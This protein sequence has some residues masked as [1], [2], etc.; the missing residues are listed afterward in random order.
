MFQY[1]QK[2]RNSKFRDAIWPIR[3][4]ELRKFIPMAIL[5][6][7]VNL[8]LNFLRTMKD[9][10]VTT[11]MGAEVISFIK[12]WFEIPSGV[13]FVL[14]YAGMCNIMSTERAFRIILMVFLIFFAAFAFILFPYKEY[15]HPD[16]ESVASYM[17]ILPN[18]KWFITIWGKWS[19]VLFYV[20][21]ELWPVVVLGLLWQLANKITS[22]EEAK[23]FY[24]FFTFFGQLNLLVC[25]SAIGYFAS[26]N[27]IFK[28]LFQNAGSTTE[29][30]VKSI[31]LVVLFSGVITLFTHLY[32]EKKT[33]KLDSSARKIVKRQKLKL[34]MIDS[35]KMIL[36][37]KYLG[38]IC[39]LMI[40][41]SVAAILLEGIWFAKVRQLYPVAEQFMAY[42]GKFMFFTGIS[43]LIFALLGSSII[44]KLGWIFGSII[45]P[46]VTLI[47]GS[48]FFVFVIIQ[49]SLESIF[50]DS[51]GLAALPIIVF[52]GGIQN[53][54]MK[55]AKYTLFDATK[56]MSYIPLDPE[57]KTKGQAAVDVVGPKI[58]KAIGAI[59]PFLSFTIF[60]SS[61]YQDIAGF[62]L[63][64][65]ASTCIIWISAVVLLSREYY[66]LLESKE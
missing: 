55:G 44:R 31:M 11:F 15:F 40:S 62:L 56:E 1:F 13:L 43:A 5:M 54:F 26:G 22:T 49:D 50:S 35:M 25:G 34:G 3:S 29:V 41:Y 39:I 59:V 38:L 2:V 4:G 57:I 66:A 6:F 17:V 52:C 24:S 21:A 7:A 42:Q 20:M 36:S 18:L 33:M 53:V 46:V 8:N 37:S 60:P 47:A 28:S 51:L 12:I 61:G 23:R 19:F 65:F 14:I 16:P 27:H 48:S 10:I 45:T 30:T 58:G 63:L 32:V 64:I 9:S